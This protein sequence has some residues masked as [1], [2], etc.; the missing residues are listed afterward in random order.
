MPGQAFTRRCA[1]LRGLDG[2]YVFEQIDEQVAVGAEHA[3]YAEI[4]IG[5]RVF[6]AN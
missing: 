4:R 2:R 1:E 5:G 6:S 3:G